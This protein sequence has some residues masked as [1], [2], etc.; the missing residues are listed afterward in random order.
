MQNGNVFNP[1]LK[2]LKDEDEQL[3]AL[4]IHFVF[5]FCYTVIPEAA[6]D[7]L[8]DHT[9]KQFQI[10]LFDFLIKKGVQYALDILIDLVHHKYTYFRNPEQSR[11]VLR[12]VRFVQQND[13][14]NVL[15]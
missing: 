15:L 14:F 3:Y 10:T 8:N 9:I 1:D 13:T 4:T 7:K 11:Q 6:W 12:Y 2:F 5:H